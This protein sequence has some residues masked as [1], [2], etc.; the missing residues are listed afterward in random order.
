MGLNRMNYNFLIYHHE[1]FSTP[2]F[3]P[4]YSALPALTVSILPGCFASHQL[5]CGQQMQTNF[6]L[7]L[8]KALLKFQNHRK[9]SFSIEAKEKWEWCGENRVLPGTVLDPVFDA[10]TEKE[11]WSLE[12]WLFLKHV[13]QTIF[14]WVNALSWCGANK[15]KSRSSFSMEIRGKKT[16]TQR[17][18]QSSSTF[19][20]GL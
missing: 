14:I 9:Q 6:N 18:K 15:A 1:Y 17:G 7:S 10:L 16:T 3:A 20:V 5:L 4:A 8:T 11:V 13:R 19:W 12:Y 2:Q